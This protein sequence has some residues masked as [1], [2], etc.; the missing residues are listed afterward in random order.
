VSFPEKAR[1]QMLNKKRMCQEKEQRKTKKENRSR[2]RC[3]LDDED[4]DKGGEG[5]QEETRQEERSPV[6]LVG[7]RGTRPFAVPGATR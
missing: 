3:G 7:Q 4:Q 5:E 1:E 6:D 2:W